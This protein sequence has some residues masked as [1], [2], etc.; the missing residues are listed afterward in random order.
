MR[1]DRDV[2]AIHG[3]DIRRSSGTGLTLIV[4]IREF[5][6]I[7]RDENTD[8]EGTED[9]EGSQ[10]VEDGV[11]GAGHDLARVL[12]LTC[13]HGNII[14]SGNSK[15]GFDETVEEANPLAK[16]AL[17]MQLGERARVLPKSETK[18]ITLRVTAKHDNKGEED[19]ADDEDDFAQ[20]SP[21]LGLTVPFDS[22]KIYQCV[23][24]DDDDNHGGKRY[25]VGPEAYNDTTGCDFKGH[26]SSFE[27]EEIP[28]RSETKG[29]VD[30]ATGEADKGRGDR[31]IR[32][33]F[34]HAQR[35]SENNGTPV[36]KGNEQATRSAFEEDI[37]NLN[38]HEKKKIAMSTRVMLR[39]WERPERAG[40]GGQGMHFHAL[41]AH[42]EQYQWCR[43]CQS[44]E[45]DET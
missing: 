23:E 17:V 25:G 5:L 38:L 15:G 3:D 42:I 14:G 21:E 22:D 10:T 34:S 36:G 7:V 2:Q 35:H 6:G 8:T 33:H 26:E 30:I 27:Y 9:E 41:Y 18:S 20:G 32:N 37:A 4:G 13:S 40:G 24:Y 39:I 31:E 19:E 16:T 1:E 11:V 45:C 29:F 43:Q 12:S 44:A 28:T